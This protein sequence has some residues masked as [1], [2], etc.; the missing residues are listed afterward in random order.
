MIRNVIKCENWDGIIFIKIMLLCHCFSKD[1]PKQ[2]KLNPLCQ[3]QAR[4]LPRGIF[5]GKISKQKS[6]VYLGFSN[7]MGRCHIVL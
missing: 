6:Q 1:K 7:P 2:Q 4:K 3:N 5:S